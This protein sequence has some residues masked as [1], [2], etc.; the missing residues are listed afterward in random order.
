MTTTKDGL[1]DLREELMRIDDVA[2]ALY[3]SCRE[4][5]LKGLSDDCNPNHSPPSHWTALT[6]IYSEVPPHV[7]R[8]SAQADRY[9]YLFTHTRCRIDTRKA[10]MAS[11]R[12]RRHVA[13]TRGPSPSSLWATRSTSTT[14][15]RVARGTR[16]ADEQKQGNIK[17]ELGSGKLS[18]EAQPTG[19][20]TE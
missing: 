17:M 4:S 11:P 12:L 6:Q 9:F 19:A 8:R 3:K 7:F 13:Q 1:E 10:A 2:Y 5:R 18:R 14:T 15:A 20:T 16:G